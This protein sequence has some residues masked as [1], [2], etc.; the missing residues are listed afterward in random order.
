MARKTGATATDNVLRDLGF[1][2]ADELSAKAMLAMR[3]NQLL[4]QRALNQ[5][6]AAQLL[7]M[8]QP[9]VSAIRRYRLQGISLERLMQALVALDQSVKIIVRNRR[10]QTHGGIVVAA[11]SWSIFLA[12]GKLVTR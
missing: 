3:I 9:K 4:D 10:P 12:G 1:P 8:P 11:A 7:R 5:T 2:D 6:K